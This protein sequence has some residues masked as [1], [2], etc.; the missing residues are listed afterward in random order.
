M[1]SIPGRLTK[2]AALVLLLT[3]LACSSEPS[4]SAKIQVENVWSWPALKSEGQTHTTGVVYLTVINKGKKP[5]RLLSAQ[6]AVAE[7]VEL[8]ETQTVGDRTMMHPAKNGVEIPA[9]GRVEFKPGGNHI[10]LIGLRRDLQP[11][12]HFQVTLQFEKGGA[13]SVQ[14]TV[15]QP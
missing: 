3:G 10:M 9:D 8:H 5:D 6:S 2:Y 4:D 11:G 7:T 13:L 1:I 15:R 14:S 12:D